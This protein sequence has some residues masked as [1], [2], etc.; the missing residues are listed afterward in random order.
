MSASA[1]V[2]LFILY[3]LVA[4][5]AKTLTLSELSRVA[6][7]PRKYAVAAPL[8]GASP[9]NGRNPLAV[10]TTFDATVEPGF[11]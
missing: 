8:N 1:K 11:S 4:S 10:G 9:L 5:P 7:I 6:C 2:P 3:S